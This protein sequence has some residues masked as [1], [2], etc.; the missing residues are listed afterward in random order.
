[1]TIETSRSGATHDPEHA[2]D[3]WI[4]HP[5]PTWCDGIHHVQSYVEDQNH[6][7]DSVRVP[8]F[9]NDRQYGDAELSAELCWN[10]ASDSPHVVLYDDGV[11]EDVKLTPAEAA[12]FIE[13]LSTLVK[14]VW[15]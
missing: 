14:R 12:L 2:D 5:C 4:V 7:S 6:T 11:K 3:W 15:A 1:M 8:M 13:R 10:I 9:L